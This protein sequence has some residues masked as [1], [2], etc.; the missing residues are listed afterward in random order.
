MQAR[1]RSPALRLFN[2][3]FCLSRGDLGEIW[4][5]FTLFDLA[6]FDEARPPSVRSKNVA[7]I[8]CANRIL[9]LNRRAK[10]HR[11]RGRG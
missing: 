4:G 11:K 1:L 6:N 2:R 7:F 5:S 3:R 8:E 9:L 10:N